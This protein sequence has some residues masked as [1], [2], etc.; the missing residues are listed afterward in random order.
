VHANAAEFE[1]PSRVDAILATYPHCLLPASGQV[2]ANGATALRPGGRWV[3]LDLKVPDNAPRWLTRLGIA[4]GG[5]IGALDE[6]IVQRPWEAIRV[7]M[8]DTLA[9]LSWTELFFGIAY[10]AA[11]SAAQ[12]RR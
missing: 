10:L 1:F 3:V 9:D 8:R 12:D 7:S 6:W 5:R 4:T 11:G 2:I